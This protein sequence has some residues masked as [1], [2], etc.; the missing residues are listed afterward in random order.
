MKGYYSMAR[1]WFDLYVQELAVPKSLLSPAEM[2]LWQG[3]HDVPVKTYDDY[4]GTE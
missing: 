3:A 4:F 1:N 2:A